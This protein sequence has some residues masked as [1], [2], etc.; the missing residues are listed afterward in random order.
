MQDIGQSERSP[1]P[2]DMALDQ[3]NKENI[4]HMS[5]GKD[6]WI[7]PD[8]ECSHLDSSNQPLMNS[9]IS[10]GFL[11]SALSG[12]QASESKQAAEAQRADIFTFSSK[13]RSAPH[14]KPLNLSSESG[15]FSVDLKEEIS[16]VWRGAQMEDDFY[17][18][19]SN[20][21]SHRAKA[22]LARHSTG[23]TIKW[24]SPD[25]THVVEYPVT[26]VVVILVTPML[27]FYFCQGSDFQQAQ[28]N[29]MFRVAMEEA[30]LKGLKG[31]AS[32]DKSK[33]GDTES[34]PRKAK[35]KR[36]P[37]PSLSSVS[38]LS[39]S[40]CSEEEAKHDDSYSEF[41]QEAKHLQASHSISRSSEPVMS[42]EIPLKKASK[43]P[44]HWANTGYAKQTSEET[45]PPRKEDSI[46]GM[47]KV[48]NLQRSVLPTCCL[49]PPGS[50][51]ESCEKAPDKSTVI[52]SSQLRT[53][54]SR[55]SLKE[56]PQESSN[57]TVHTPVSIFGGKC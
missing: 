57:L 42:K 8:K 12:D 13:P 11:T 16:G 20:E 51:P 36:S 35:R 28:F 18:S 55:K 23:T 2:F 15:S 39:F 54:I 21:D 43:S 9:E 5:L 45:L 29:A 48:K 56:I 25:D 52:S 27:N 49:S 22:R 47:G 1:S 17:G 38:E 6:E 46:V 32:V 30:G 44:E 41:G 19:E 53:S 31:E 14:G 7:F 37:T 50:A 24:L 34:K 10:Y 26:M 3:G 40:Y 4:H 33:G